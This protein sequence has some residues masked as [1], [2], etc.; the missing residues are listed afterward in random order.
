MAVFNWTFF[1]FA[2]FG[3]MLMD[4]SPTCDGSSCRKFQSQRR[5]SITSTSAE[6]HFSALC[7]SGSAGWVSD[8][9]NI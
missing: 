9:R 6:K 4:G 5:S 1:L 3:N 2:A 8:I 7:A